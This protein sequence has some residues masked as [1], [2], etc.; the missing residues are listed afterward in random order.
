[1][2]GPLGLTQEAAARTDAPSDITTGIVSAVTSR[3]IDVQR[4]GGLVSGAAH[5]SSYNPAV[6]DTVTMISYSNSWIVL[7]RSV[8]PGTAVDNST[9][10]TGIG[11]ILLDGM[12]LSGANVDLA[13]STGA[14]VTVPRYGVSFYHPPGHWVMLLWTYNWY[15]SVANDVMTFKLVEAGGT[16]VATIE[17]T[18]AG[19][20]AIGNGSTLAVMTPP[21]LGGVSR[22]YT[23]TLQ[24]FSGTG[25]TRA[26]DPSVRR[27]SLLAYDLGDQS[28]IRTV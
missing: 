11:A 9:P 13:I 19:V 12:V 5:L 27:G 18:Q 26:Y 21:T 24:R 2:T 25:T 20:G 17:N 7:G 28:I 14:L 15:S 23:M 3:G 22:S 16:A 1:M 4:G 6:G 8:G 10:G